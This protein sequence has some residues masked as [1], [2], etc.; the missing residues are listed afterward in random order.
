MYEQIIKTIEENRLAEALEQVKKIPDDKW[1]KYNFLG[2]ILLNQNKLLESKE[3]FEKAMEREPSNNDILFNYSQVLLALGNAK[4]AKTYLMRVSE[5]DE[6]V[7][8]ILEEIED[9]IKQSKKSGMSKEKRQ[10]PIETGN[11]RQK[12]ADDY[13]KNPIDSDMLKEF[14]LGNQKVIINKIQQLLSQKKY[15]KVLSICNHW[16]RNINQTH[17]LIFYFIGVAANGISDFKAAIQYHKKALETDITFADLRNRRSKYQ[18]HYKEEIC[19][20]IGCGNQSYEIVNVSNQSISEDNLELVNPLRI[21]VKCKKCGLIYAN[22]MPEEETLNL[23]YS[24]VAKEKFGGIYGNI[25]DRFEFQVNMANKRLEKIEAYTESLGSLLDIGAGV[26]FFL[27]TALD[28]GWKAV[29]LELTP[30][31]CDYAKKNFDLDLIQKNFYSFNDDNVYDVVTLFEVIE[32]LRTPLKDLKEISRFIKKDG[33]LVLATPIQNSLF[34]KKMK[35]QNVFWNVVS[36]LSFFP[37]ETIISYLKQAGFSI[38]ESNM[39]NEG[40]GRMEF[41]CQK[42]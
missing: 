35:D 15:G 41:Y 25:G 8:S 32:H 27:G 13:F 14:K 9:R 7:C 21:W 38:L 22:P 37:K 5:K 29:G 28:R 20:C 42:L 31:D 3:A 24:K 40:M 34:G 30:E 19:S 17:A 39:S 2:L 4:E 11:E 6:I 23:Y 10:K 12:E 1:E 33:L 36:H 26:G 16:L 18:Y